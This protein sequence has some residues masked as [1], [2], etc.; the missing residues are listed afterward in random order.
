MS[1]CTHPDSNAVDN[2]VTDKFEAD[3][4]EN[5]AKGIP[6]ED[7]GF[8]EIAFDSEHHTWQDLDNYYR[9]VILVQHNDKDYTSNLKNKCMTHLV[10]VYKIHEK[11]DLATVEYYINEQANLP[12]LVTPELLVLCLNRMK[13]HWEEFRIAQLME[14]VRQKQ[15]Q[16]VQKKFASK[17]HVIKQKTDE[18]NQYLMYSNAKN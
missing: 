3:S 12:Y 7:I 5:R 16:G 6:P 1:S 10:K 11:A 4:R 8:N 18:Y 13:G 17:P 14:D 15:I 9:Q 2:A